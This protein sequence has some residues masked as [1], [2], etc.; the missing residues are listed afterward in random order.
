MLKEINNSQKMYTITL[1][2][3]GHVPEKGLADL[4]I[5]KCVGNTVCRS[6]I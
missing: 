4:L 5:K 6:E 2:M 1:A 3:S